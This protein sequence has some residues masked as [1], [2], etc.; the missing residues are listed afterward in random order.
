MQN[1]AIDEFMISWE[2]RL[3]LCS[4]RLI[5]KGSSAFTEFREAASPE[6]ADTPVET[7]LRD[8]SGS[9]SSERAFFMSI[10]AIG[11]RQTFA[12]QTKVMVSFFMSF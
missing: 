1:I 3:L 11:L 2:S 9:S 12:V 4:E 8:L 10:S 6:S 7:I 5:P